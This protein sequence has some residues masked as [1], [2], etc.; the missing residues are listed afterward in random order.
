MTIEIAL[1]DQRQ[2]LRKKIENRLN[3]S[4]LLQ[5]LSSSSNV[6]IIF[7]DWALKVVQTRLKEIVLMEKLDLVLAV[8]HASKVKLNAGL[9]GS[10]PPMCKKYNWNS[11]ITLTIVNSQG[12]GPSKPKYSF[13]CNP[14][15]KV[16]ILE[17]A[18]N[19]PDL[20]GHQTWQ[21]WI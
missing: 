16:E 15:R 6:L 9:W 1:T 18:L 12:D 2:I 5:K 10:A 17:M 11:A 19:L 8:P 20:I 7:A 13:T 14:A 21:I 4:S 3:R